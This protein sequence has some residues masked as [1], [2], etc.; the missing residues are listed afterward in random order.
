MHIN[1]SSKVFHPV[2]EVR[3]QKGSVGI[4]KNDSGVGN[5]TLEQDT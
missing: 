3:L 2:L 5:D 4:H 1:A